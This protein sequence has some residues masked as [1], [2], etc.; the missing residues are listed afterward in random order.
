MDRKIKLSLLSASVLAALSFS[1]HAESHL[2]D[3]NT[4]STFDGV[5]STKPLCTILPV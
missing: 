4:G 5:V 1:T 2:I 3:L